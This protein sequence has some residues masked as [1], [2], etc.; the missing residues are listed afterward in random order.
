MNGFLW[1]AIIF[2]TVAFGFHAWESHGGPKW[3][4]TVASV[5]AGAAA[6]L[7]LLIAVCGAP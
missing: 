6:V 4:A 5:V 1:V 2:V 3:P 7:V